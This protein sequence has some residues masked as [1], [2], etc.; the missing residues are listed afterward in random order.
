MHPKSRYPKVVEYEAESM[1]DGKTGGLAKFS[2]ERDV[3]FDTP[4]LFSGREQGASPGE[5]FVSSLL[6]CFNNTFLNF[7][8]SFELE[9]VSMHLQG[10]ATV[11]FE[12]GAYKIIGIEIS[13]EV[14]VAD[15]ELEIGERC[16]ALTKEYYHIARSIRD[17]IPFTYN[18]PVREVFVDDK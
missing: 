10:K 2:G 7:Q 9:L 3:V 15:G 13:G 11:H 5:L 16:V 1:W 17:S 18:I 14:V 12:N 8:R 4:Q 6:G